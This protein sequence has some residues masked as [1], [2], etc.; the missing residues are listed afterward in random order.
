MAECTSG[1]S[2]DGEDG[3][4]DPKDIPKLHVSD[5]EAVPPQ[6]VPLETADRENVSSM[7]H[8]DPMLNAESILVVSSFCRNRP[9]ASR[10]L[11]N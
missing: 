10:W 2:I 7:L 5:P 4:A 1:D 9:A 6:I 8:V 11:E 3:S